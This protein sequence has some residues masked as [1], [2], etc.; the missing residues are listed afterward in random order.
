MAEPPDTSAATAPREFT[1]DE[2]AA[3]TRVPSRTIRFYQSKKA[4]PVPERRGRKAVYGEAHVERLRLIAQLQDQGLTIKA[5]RNVLARADRGELDVSDWLGLSTHLKTPSTDDRPLL[6]TREAL[7]ERA[8]SDRDGL[9]AELVHEGL[10]ERTGDRFSV[11]SPAL[12]DAT[13]RL[14][15]AGIGLAASAE[16]ARLLRRH[17]S[18]AAAQ[19]S[20]HFLAHLESSTDLSDPERLTEAVQTLRPVGLEVVRVIFAREMDAALS[21]AVVSGRFAGA[22]KRS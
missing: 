1:I 8:G 10:A 3:E 18:K 16:A 12:L 2:L 9:L 14:D 5:I 22:L 15:R 6:L 11:A 20:A 4:L 19:V 7:L 17:L 13:M 21:D